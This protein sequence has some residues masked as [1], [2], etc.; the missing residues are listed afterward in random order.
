MRVYDRWSFERKIDLIFIG[1]IYEIVFIFI[2]VNKLLICDQNINFL[3]KWKEC[4]MQETR[5]DQSTFMGI[6]L[7]LNLFTSLQK[8]VLQ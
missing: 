4:N 3:Y 8:H 7:D 1:N 2:Y 6:L 5:V